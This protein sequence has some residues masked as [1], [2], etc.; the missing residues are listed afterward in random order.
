MPKTLMQT[1]QTLTDSHPFK[2]TIKNTSNI[3]ITV[4]I[5]AQDEHNQVKFTGK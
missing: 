5:I 3:F 4:K 2:V 1:P